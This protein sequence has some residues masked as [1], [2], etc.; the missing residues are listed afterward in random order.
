MAMT[1][2]AGCSGDGL[3]DR[4]A[5]EAAIHAMLARNQA[6]TNRGDPDEV[7]RTYLPDGDI[8]IVGRERLSGWDELR[9]NE[10]EF[11]RMPGFRWEVTID[12]IRFLDRDV[13]IIESSGLT[14][15]ASGKIEEKHTMVVSRQD[16]DWRIAAVRIMEFDERP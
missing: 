16:D 13:A 3:P 1:F 4:D 9:R 12:S 2:A 5:D 14:T 8:W 15:H 10:E 7:I 11:N 6:A